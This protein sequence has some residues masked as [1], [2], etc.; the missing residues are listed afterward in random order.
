MVS[1]EIQGFLLSALEAGVSGPAAFP[2]CA[3]GHIKVLICDVELV[4]FPQRCCDDQMKSCWI[5]SNLRYH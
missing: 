5:L 4:K 3:L 2:S 1:R